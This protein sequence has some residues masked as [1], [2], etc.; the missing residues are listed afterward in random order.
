[1]GGGGSPVAPWHVE[2]AQ[3]V[4]GQTMTEGEPSGF[5]CASTAAWQLVASQLVV[6]HTYVWLVRTNALDTVLAAV[7][8]DVVST[9]AYSPAA[10]KLTT[11]ITASVF[12]KCR[13]ASAS[14]HGRTAHSRICLSSAGVCLRGARRTS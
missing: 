11:M 1:M 14:S 2:A 8:P 9:P 3:P 12:W 7:L 6:G 5:D 4:R 13:I 10:V